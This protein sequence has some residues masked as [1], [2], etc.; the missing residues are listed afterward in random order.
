MTSLIQENR[1]CRISEVLNIPYSEALS[2]VFDHPETGLGR[3]KPRGG[4]RSI[5]V[6]NGL[7]NTRIAKGRSLPKGWRYG[8]IKRVLARA[9]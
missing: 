4:S 7:I 2:W 9:A 6:N 3:G 8:R 5:W 1:A